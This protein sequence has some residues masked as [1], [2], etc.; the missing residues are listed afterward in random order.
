MNAVATPAKAVQHP[1]EMI[2]DDTKLNVRIPK[3]LTEVRA[4]LRNSRGEK[5]E[6]V[7]FVMLRNHATNNDGRAAQRVEVHGPRD[8]RP[9]IVEVRSGMVHLKVMSGRVLVWADSLWGNSVEALND[10]EVDVI[11]SPERK[12]TVIAHHKSKVTIHKGHDSWG[13]QH[14]NDQAELVYAV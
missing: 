10:S 6:A 11:V 8:G 9:L 14:A 5:D 4:A 13:H 1:L 2:D 7:R 12:A 3:D